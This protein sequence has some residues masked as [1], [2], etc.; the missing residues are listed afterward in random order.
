MQVASKC[1]LR[2]AGEEVQNKSLS[3]VPYSV[4][5]FEQKAIQTQQIKK[6]KKK[7]LPFPSLPKR[8][9]VKDLVQEEN[10][11]TIT[12]DDYKAYGL[13]WFPQGEHG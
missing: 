9:Q 1:A 8:I 2:N 13:V 3:D 7:F 11:R 5:C 4:V 12:T 6:E 10:Q